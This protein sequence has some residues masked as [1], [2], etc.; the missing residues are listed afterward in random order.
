MRAGRVVL[1]SVG[2]RRVWVVAP[3]MGALE[4]FHTAGWEGSAR[5]PARHPNRKRKAFLGFLGCISFG[6]HQGECF[7]EP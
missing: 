1:V 2:G 3:R 6:L 5:P 4:G 7:W